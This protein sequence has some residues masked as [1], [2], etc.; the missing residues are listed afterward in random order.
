MLPIIYP[1]NKGII[2]ALMALN[3]L[4]KELLID[5]STPPKAITNPIIVPAHPPSI[6]SS[7]KTFPNSLNW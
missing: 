3:K 4:P 5:L 2:Q 1:Y 7:F 6:K